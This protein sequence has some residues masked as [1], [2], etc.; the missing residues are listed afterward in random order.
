MSLFSISCFWY[1]KGLILY[2]FCNVIVIVLV[3][4]SMTMRFQNLNMPPPLYSLVLVTTVD[5][6]EIL[7][8]ILTI[9]LSDLKNTMIIIS[10]FIELQ[11]TGRYFTEYSQNL[12]KHLM[13]TQGLLSNPE[14]LTENENLLINIDR[15]I[16][17]Q[18]SSLLNSNKASSNRS[19]SDNS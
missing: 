7:S 16:F 11:N 9:L 8:G 14:T 3:W 4:L 5:F 15:T 6:G 2:V 1:T 18:N 13:V 10:V 12:L 17:H 19:H